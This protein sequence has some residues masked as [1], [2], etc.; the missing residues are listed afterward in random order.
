MRKLKTQIILN[1]LVLLTPLVTALLL[2]NF[3]GWVKVNEHIAYAGKNVV[4][5]YDRLL[6]HD[7]DFVQY[8]LSNKLSNDAD[9]LLLNYDNDSLDAY[10][11]EQSILS[12]F[13]QF[14]QSGFDSVYAMAVYARKQ[15]VFRI[16][17][18]NFDSNT[19]YEDN[20]TLRQEILKC[21]K[22]GETY[23]WHM[24]DAG[25]RS[26]L[27]RILSRQNVSFA[28]VID[29]ERFVKPQD[30]VLQDQQGYLFYV[31]NALQPLNQKE[32]VNNNQIKIKRS[33]AL[34]YIS[35]NADK[36]FMIVQKEFKYAGLLQVYA[37]P[38]T[39]SFKTYDL[40]QVCLFIVTIGVAAMIPIGYYYLKK[41]YVI[42]I[43]NLVETMGQIKDGN[44]DK[45]LEEEYHVEEFSRMK[46]SFNEMLKSIRDLKINAYEQQLRIQNTQLQ[47][48]QI[49][50]RPHFFL[51]CLKNIYALSASGANDKLQRMTLVLSDYMRG[52]IRKEDILIYLQDEVKNV[53]NYLEL[54]EMG[55]AKKPEY[56]IDF[57]PA[58]GT[59]KIPPMTILTFVENSVKHGMCEQ[60]RLVIS[61]RVCRLCYEDEQF[62]SIT[63]L[64]N[65]NGFPEEILE[66]LNRRDS[67]LE[68]EHIGIDNVKQ[69]IHVIY[70]DRATILFSNSG[71]ACVEIVLPMWEEADCDSFNR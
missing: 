9:T 7:L 42:P 34:Y 41:S 23:D 22:Q 54:Q 19:T 71:G 48:L 57:D 4:E 46:T 15:E 39:T 69:R 58:L 13:D 61:V 26:Y 11:I 8:Y 20:Y 64:D 52:L 14:L 36:R 27:I 47:Y 56:S 17:Y 45:Y 31:D 59:I 37:F 49:Q 33:D 32:F 1:L 63:I 5:I 6:E 24:I 3:H 30:Y 16:H 2:Y 40:L 68:R 29:L 51:N 62:L 43:E 50:I 10:L 38:Y 55:L 35:G 70:N 21:M 66:T 25:Q 53:R 18:H 65:G 28:V 67:V 12:D 44:S 60:K